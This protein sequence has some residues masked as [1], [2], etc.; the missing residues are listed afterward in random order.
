[1]GLLVALNLTQIS[2]FLEQTF[3]WELFPK[4]VYYIDQFPSQ[5]S[6]GDVMAIVMTT[7]FISFVATLY[8]SWQASKLT[9]S[10]AIRYE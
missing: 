10:E 1:L 8:P 9:P 5:V 2:D 6:A 4:D 7:L 3:H